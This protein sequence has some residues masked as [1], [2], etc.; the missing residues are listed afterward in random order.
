MDFPHSSLNSSK[1]SLSILI[2][3][4]NIF[5]GKLDSSTLMVLPI[6]I[7]F[8]PSSAV[9]ILLPEELGFSALFE[10]TKV[11]YPDSITSFKI[12]S[13]KKR[14]PSIAITEQV[15]F[16]SLKPKNKL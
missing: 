14:S 12:F 3:P 2:S 1:S 9:K 8:F 16:N 11:L 5:Q 10:R 7:I 15:S 6:A 13:S 4:P